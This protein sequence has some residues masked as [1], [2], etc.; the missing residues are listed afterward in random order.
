MTLS[1][2]KKHVEISWWFQPVLL[3]LDWK[4]NFQFF[5]IFSTD[6]TYLEKIILSYIAAH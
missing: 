1:T 5:V 3:C 4:K 6:E 2:K